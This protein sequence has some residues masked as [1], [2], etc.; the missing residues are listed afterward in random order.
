MRDPLRGR[1]LTSDSAQEV[2]SLEHRQPLLRTSGGTPRR[3]GHEP[4][5]RGPTR[6]E[7]PG[8]LGLEPQLV[9][10]GTSQREDASTSTQPLCQGP[11]GC[12]LG[13]YLLLQWFSFLYDIKVLWPSLE[14]AEQCLFPRRKGRRIFR[15][16]VG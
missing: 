7:R 6:E 8:E 2:L 4:K 1:I 3:A 16:M 12:A 15:G 14:P 11:S 9:A 10:A 13:N 5:T